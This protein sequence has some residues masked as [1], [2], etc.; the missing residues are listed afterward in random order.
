MVKSPNK[1]VKKLNVKQKRTLVQLSIAQKQQ[2]V[3]G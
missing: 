2:V 3:L 1:N